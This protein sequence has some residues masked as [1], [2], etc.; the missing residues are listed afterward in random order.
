MKIQG[1]IVVVTG[2]GQGLGASIA[3]VAVQRGAAGI[4]V[5]DINGER[6]TV[7]AS[8][9]GGLAV[10]A[11][12]STEAGVKDVVAQAIERFGRV[13]LYI[14]NAGIGSQANIFDDDAAWQLQW[15]VHVMAHVWAARALLPA[16]LERGSGGLVNVASSVALSSQPR[17]PVY[18][19]TK[20]AGLALAETM[21]ID[22]H[23][24]G[25][26]IGCACPQ[27]MRTPMLM[28]QLESADDAGRAFG[29]AS[30]IE[31]IEAATRIVDGIEADRFLILTHDEVRT[32]AQRRADDH[33]RWLAGMRRMYRSLETGAKS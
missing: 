18:N 21:A 33:D 26:Y 29:L 6:V 15:N 25:I 27:G 22:Y 12:I 16:M 4:V 23:D 10:T 24:K 17:M 31:P 30:A 28:G 8:R 32:Y 19:S 9:L 14:S 5:T 11:D 2:A 3:E 13:D 7:V 20:H 1:K